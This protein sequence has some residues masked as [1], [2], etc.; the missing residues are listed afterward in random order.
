MKM[1]KSIAIVVSDFNDEITGRMLALAQAEAKAL[2][3][4]IAKTVHVPGAYDIPLIAALLLERE[5]VDALV[6]LGCVIKGET[7]HDELVAGVCAR[8]L[9]DLSIEFAKPVGLGVIGPG[10]THAQ[11]QTRADGYAKRAV[12]SA[13]RLMDAQEEAEKE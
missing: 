4:E 13:L 8:Q 10:A 7:G 6:A 5:D 3:A 12:K 9:N 2:G 11:A 1:T